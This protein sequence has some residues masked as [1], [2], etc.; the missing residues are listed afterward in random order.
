MQMAGVY[1]IVMIWQTRR[2]RCINIVR[3]VTVGVLY[4]TTR[5]HTTTCVCGCVFLTSLI[6]FENI[7]SL[8]QGTQSRAVHGRPRTF[9]RYRSQHRFDYTRPTVWC[10]IE[11]VSNVWRRR[12]DDRT[13]SEIKRPRGRR[14]PFSLNVLK[15]KTSV[16][17]AGRWEGRRKLMVDD[18]LFSFNFN[19]EH[20][21]SVK[22][23]PT[24]RRS[25]RYRLSLKPFH[26]VPGCTLITVGHY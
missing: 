21:V 2:K 20:N 11:N 6:L 23:T 17:V 25:S 5:A 24:F 1:H 13:K 22:L 26:N 4:C 16:A 19:F 12:F 14:E 8:T 3:C 7:V 9:L 15:R 18:F 10:F